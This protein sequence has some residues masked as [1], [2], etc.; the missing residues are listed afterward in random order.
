L[1][2][3]GPPISSNT[4]R[5]R[6]DVPTCE[7]SMPRP[8]MQPGSM[9]QEITPFLGSDVGR[10]LATTPRRPPCFLQ[11][12][13]QENHLPS[14]RRKVPNLGGVT[15]FT[16]DIG[17]GGESAVE[18]RQRDKG[19]IAGRWWWMGDRL[20]D[21]GRREDKG[22]ASLVRAASAAMQSMPRFGLALDPGGLRGEFFFV[23]VPVLD[24]VFVRR[25][26]PNIHGRDASPRWR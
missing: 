19:K 6:K 12:R 25:N 18:G 3:T 14:R 17:Y 26:H 21:Q 22:D 24:C 11:L 1:R 4:C 15:A 2:L 5:R 10:R 23:F 8:T 7:Q 16:S 20:A 9:G 13:R